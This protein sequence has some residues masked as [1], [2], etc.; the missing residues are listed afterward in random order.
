TTS[1]LFVNNDITLASGN[2]NDSGRDITLGGNWLA[3]GGMF[4][5]SPS[6]TVTFSGSNQSITTAASAFHHLV[7]SGSGA[8][9]F[10]DNLTVN[11]NITFSTSFVPVNSGFAITLNGNWT[12]NGLF[13]RNN[14][15]INLNGS[16]S[17]II[18][19]SSTT[20]F[21]NITVNK[22]GGNVLVNSNVNLYQTLSIQSPTVFDADGV[23]TGVFTIMST[24]DD[25]V[26]D[27][28]VA[29]L[30]SGSSV[31]G[32]VTVQRYMAPEVPG[33]TRVYRYISSP[34][35]GQNISDWQDDFPITGTFSNPNSEFPNGSGITSICGVLLRPASPS[36]FRY[37]EPNS[38]T[39]AFDLGWEAYPSSGLS[40][41]SPI[42]VGRGYAAFIRE[43]TSPTTIDVRG[44]INQGAISFNSIV[45]L[46][47][48]GDLED[49]FNLVGNPYPS[50]IDWNTSLGWT[51][52][53]ISS[54][55]YIRDNGNS[56]GFITYDYTDNIP[57]VIAT[58]QAFWVRVTGTPSF[59][60]NEQAK[61][62]NTATFYR[63][64]AID[65]LSINLVKG[66][67]VDKAIVKINPE[68]TGSLDDFD[69]PKLDNSLFD[70]STLS[71]DGLDM[72]VNS[73][74]KMS[75]DGV[76]PIK[77]KDMTS[78]T[79]QISFD[80]LGIFTDMD[81]E[82]FDHYTHELIDM[83]ETLVY[84]FAI[85]ND[86]ASKASNR[87]ELRF[88][89]DEEINANLAITTSAGIC[90]NVD[91]EVTVYNAQ[92]GIDYYA[93]LDGLVIS[94][95]VTGANQNIT[96]NI[97]A[98]ALSLGLN[99]LVIVASNNCSEQQEMNLGPKISV[100]P[101]LAPNIVSLVQQCNE[102][103]VTLSA[104]EVPMNAIVSWYESE[105]SDSPIFI[106]KTFTT[107]ELLKSKTYYASL[108]LG[109]CEGNRK[110]VVASVITFDPA[111]IAL[112]NDTLYSNYQTG[113]QWY[114]DNQIIESATKN[115]F[116]PTESGLYRL[117]ATIGDGSCTSNAEI[118]MIITASEEEQEDSIVIY[119]NPVSDFLN[120]RTPKNFNNV[121]S[122]IGGGG[123]T[124]TEIVLQENGD[125]KFAH[126][127]LTKLS[128]GVY[129]LLT[130]Q[131]G[132]PVHFK[133]IRE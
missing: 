4:I 50:A 89:K 81:I 121:I 53:G 31:T 132:K 12:N 52:T 23:G 5:S 51:R 94:E 27:A 97:P 10:Q 113:N 9:S 39:G 29:A 77:I 63:T 35:S 3:T 24:N 82:I 104:I 71:E 91:A 117:E 124:I 114:R 125:G 11:G 86:I 96:L 59:T 36:L 101:L 102:G 110:A 70:I 33:T 80:R 25:P 64:G 40:S 56:G 58:G 21:T 74:D 103:T 15:T 1:D 14:E 54:V 107:P 83:S 111:T 116:I 120:I 65:K 34:A 57:L 75:C 90:E 26:A 73:F 78:G 79:Y 127:D 109:G 119:P 85:T 76:L 37:I 122:L 44:P 47:S 88:H 92:F 112:R 99:E 45:S 72:A 18:S 84:S 69:G 87:L 38:G 49:G 67:V 19:G 128:A 60:I 129:Y 22:S 118:S 66:N 42:Q 16:F 55:I 68:S 106:G 2:L 61:T 126:Y 46:T 48:N 8:K 17:Q 43:C 41:A 105:N 28:R 108:S 100:G 130:I 123:Q 20:E 131:Q 133:I 93:M 32:N 13:I 6:A 7:L 115:Y 95:H 98:Q 62:S 30:P